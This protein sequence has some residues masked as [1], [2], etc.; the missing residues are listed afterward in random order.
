MSPSTKTYYERHLPHW[1]PPGKELFVT[2]RLADSLPRFFW[3]SCKQ[4]SHGKRFVEFDGALDAGRFGPHWLRDPRVAELVVQAFHHGEQARRLYRLL[5]Y[6]VM[7]NHVHLLI[8]PTA[9]LQKITQ[10]LKGYTAFQAHKILGKCGEAFWQDESFDH[11]V[12]DQS[13]LEKILRYIE[14]NPVA[15]GLVPIPE[16]WPWSSAVFRMPEK[17]Q[18]SK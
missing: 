2:W 4:A 9:P 14:N 5:A 11:W 8:K 17:T 3:R 16:G 13:E 15:A 10:T 7:P 12:R 6:V 18:S 1:Q